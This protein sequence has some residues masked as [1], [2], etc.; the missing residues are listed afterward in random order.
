VALLCCLVDIGAGPLVV[1]HLNHQLR[2]ADSDGDE[3]FVRGLTAGVASLEFC[4]ERID[5]LARARA[6]Q[7]NLEN[8]ARRVRYDWLTRIARQHQ[9]RWVAT[10]HTADDQAET[11]LH[12]L[13]RGTGLKGL[14]GIP[15]RRPLAAGVAVV[16]PLL[17]TRRPEVLAFLGERG[18]AFREDRSNPDLRFTRNRIRHELLPHLAEHYNPAIASVL[19]RL[20]EQA[21][22]VY[23]DVEDRARRLLGLAE[24]PRAASVLVFDR[25]RLTAESRLLV[26]ELFRLVWQREGWPA[27]AMS[28]GDWDRI[29][30]V[31]LGEAAA[32]DL[33]GRIHVQGRE[34]VVQ[35]VLGP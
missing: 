28:F 31:A 14:R 24:L 15:A 23:R 7:D 8:T 4:C 29:A 9:A 27:G 22:E 1:A 10:G 16:R 25:N 33:P 35:I 17:R 12:R 13:L 21:D 11:V 19:G 20:A 6:E 5:V 30:A 32:V 18:Q 2:G 34:R 3:E 26:R